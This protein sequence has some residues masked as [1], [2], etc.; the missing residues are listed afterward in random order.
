MSWRWLAPP[1]HTLR[2]VA[3]AELSDLGLIAVARAETTG[4]LEAAAASGDR[5]D[6]KLNARELPRCGEGEKEPRNRPKSR[7]E[8]STFSLFRL[9]R[10]SSNVLSDSHSDWRGDAGRLP[11][12]PEFH[13]RG[14]FAFR[15]QTFGTG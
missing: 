8:N 14:V 13:E 5:A 3:G 11:L 6:E 10:G 4:H 2:F 9:F 7:K 12:P 15:E 1:C